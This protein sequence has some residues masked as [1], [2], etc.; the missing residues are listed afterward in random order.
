MMFE[1]EAADDQWLHWWTFMDEETR[2]AESTQVM[3]SLENPHVSY[4]LE[5]ATP[6]V[7]VWCEVTRDK[8]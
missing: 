2:L 7:N 6:K 4:E 5:Q 8:M 1:Q 3:L